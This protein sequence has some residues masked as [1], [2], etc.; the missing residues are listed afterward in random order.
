M[1]KIILSALFIVAIGSIAST[2][3]FKE[4]SVGRA[5]RVGVIISHIHDCGHPNCFGYQAGSDDPT[6]PSCSM[7]R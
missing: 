2:S 3:N 7:C 6:C 4:K 1:K 5:K